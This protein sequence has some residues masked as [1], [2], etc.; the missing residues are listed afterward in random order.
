LHGVESHQSTAVLPP[1]GERELK[2]TFIAT[3]EAFLEWKRINRGRSPRTVEVYRLALRRLGIFFDER[4]PLAATPDELVLWSGKWLHDL[5]LKDPLSRKTHVAACR[6]FYKW[7]AGRGL[8]RRNPAISLAHAKVGR[9]LPSVMSLD[10]AERLMWAPDYGTFLG[11]RD[12]AMLGLLMG[13]GLRVSGLVRLNEGNVMTEVI[14]GQPRLV[15]W[16]KEK[17]EKERK[18]PVPVQA[19]LLLRL[20]L[21]HPELAAI[22]RT[23][24]DGD[25]VLFVSTRNRNVPAHEYRGDAR[26]LRRQ[27]VLQVVKRLGKIAGISL[28]MQHVHAIRHMYGTEL[29]E[30]DVPTIT[31][32]QLLG[33]SDPKSTLIYQHLAMRKMTRVADKANPLSKLRTPVSDLLSRL[34]PSP[35]RK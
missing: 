24:P 1:P 14:D 3:V 23:L 27:A 16:V 20:Y 11:V 21:E 4:D 8:I 31:A 33:H 35:S 26:R 2:V 29:A 32:S 34:G 30:E 25:R 12:A 28:E 22:D 19:D 17:G 7:A 6:E 15:L 5:G 18:I 13:C 9:R 10:A